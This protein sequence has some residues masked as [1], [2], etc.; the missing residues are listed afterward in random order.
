MNKAIAILIGFAAIINLMP[1][2]GALSAGRVAGLYDVAFDGP[3]LAI[4]LRHRALL[5]VIV[6]GLLAAAVFRAD[7]RGVA[8]L[9][10]LVSA[11]S[12][13]AIALAEGSFNGAIRR[14]IVADLILIASLVA[15]AV[16]IRIQPGS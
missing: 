9:V 8:I 6:G 16:L 10:G 3:D 13:I 7:L 1:V 2:V 4:L 14:V 12:F 15:A 5:L 11:I